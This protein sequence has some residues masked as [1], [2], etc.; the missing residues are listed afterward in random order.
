MTKSSMI[1]QIALNL[2]T[3]QCLNL[4]QKSCRSSSNLKSSI[5]LSKGL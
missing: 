3:R 1:L 2:D 4:S 5:Y